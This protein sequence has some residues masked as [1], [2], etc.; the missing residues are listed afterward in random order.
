MENKI[1]IGFDSSFT[2]EC[3]KKVKHKTI[4]DANKAANILRICTKSN[5]AIYVCNHCGFWHVG[6]SRNDN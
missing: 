6:R 3:G 2:K 4:S 1:N 5:I